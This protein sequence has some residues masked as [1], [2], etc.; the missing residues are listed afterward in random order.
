[1]K[2]K[3]LAVFLTGCSLYVIGQI[4]PENDFFQSPE[5]SA[6]TQEVQTPVSLSTGTLNVEIPLYTLTNGDIK[7]PITMSYDASGVRAESHP[8]WVG[9]NWNLKAGGKIT[10]IVNGLPDEYNYKYTFVPGVADSL[11]CRQGYLYLA[12][13][14]GML[15]EGDATNIQEEAL[16]QAVLDTHLF[17][18]EMLSCKYDYEPDEFIFNFCGQ[19]GVFYFNA[20]GEVVLKGMKGYRINTII[21]RIPSYACYYYYNT[22]EKNIVPAGYSST[23]RDYYVNLSSLY[24]PRIDVS[25]ILGFEITDPQGFKYYFGMYEKAQNGTIDYFRD[26]FSEVEISTPF[27]EELHL[28]QIN[29]WNLTK[30]VSPTGHEE[31]FSYEPGPFLAQLNMCYTSIVKTERWGAAGI[32]QLTPT[33][34]YSGNIIRPSYLAKI[35]GGNQS[36]IFNRVSANDLEYDYT[37][38]A[39]NLYYY[40]S[41]FYNNDN[42]TQA[43]CEELNEKIG[44]GY[45][46]PVS[47]QNYEPYINTG[48]NGQQI[49]R[50]LPTIFR[51][52]YLPKPDDDTTTRYFKGT[53][54]FRNYERIRSQKLQSISITNPGIGFKFDYL[55]E[56]SSRLQLSSISYSQNNQL[57]YAFQYT[58]PCIVPYGTGV[59][60]DCGYINHNDSYGFDF[61]THFGYNYSNPPSINYPPSGSLDNFASYRTPWSSPYV[62]LQA[63]KYPTGGTKEFVFEGN[64][65]DSVVTRSET[66]GALSIVPEANGVGCGLRIKEIRE[67]NSDGTLAKR[68]RYEYA[69]GILNGRCEYYYPTYIAKA[70]STY[71]VYTD[72]TYE[73][74]FTTN[75]LLPISQNPGL[76]NVTYSKVTEIYEDNGKTEYFFSNHDTDPDDNATAM[77]IGR[78]TLFTPLSSRDLQR[79]KLLETKT[80]KEGDPSPVKIETYKYELMDPWAFIPA[81]F[82]NGETFI[83]YADPGFYYKDP[84]TIEDTRELFYIVDGA[85]YKIYT[86]PYNVTKKTESY[87]YPEG[88]TV[89]KTTFFIYDGMN[90]ISTQTESNGIDVTETAY[91]YPYSSYPYHFSEQ[92]YADMTTSNIN[93]PVIDQT[94]TRNGVEI[95]RTRNNYSIFQSLY[96]GP[97]YLPS[98]V[99]TSTTGESGL[100]TKITYDKYDDYGR[101][102][103][104]TSATGKK[105]SYIWGDDG[106][107]IVAKVD[108]CDFDTIVNWPDDFNGFL[109]LYHRPY[110]GDVFTDMY[111]GWS[112]DK[113]IRNIPN[114]LVYSVSYRDDLG[115]ISIIKDPS[116]RCKY[117][118]YDPIGRLTGIQDEDHNDIVRYMYHFI[119]ENIK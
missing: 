98:S 96:N 62:H 5:V 80:Y 8:T 84:T 73:S 26:D 24:T 105:T 56:P 45:P 79:S 95:A 61:V 50:V 41:K 74:L 64:R 15:Y 17:T 67:I 52:S 109:K 92:V 89:S 10:R 118:D 82:I 22:Y 49:Y 70:Y 34:F 3:L 25:Y 44:A 9:L 94:V 21:R 18:T 4:M 113:A 30:I 83:D 19:T 53:D 38:L 40:K 51:V 6:L 112:L 39:K 13:R 54:N 108:N 86:S 58:G 117:Y 1:M 31:T 116:G 28:P 115:C 66:T 93:S 97:L 57:M 75:S 111:N 90:Q 88:R 12:G 110:P 71:I 114:A 11:I 59:G 103:Q 99:Q 72:Y 104:T 48:D 23:L 47:L 119:Y 46:Y 76:G 29:S 27:Y 20:S 91:S 36:A 33:L 37:K 100:K 14:V 7:V 63:I 65:Y 87:N 35:E 107:Y 69:G 32:S 60:D 2:K 55:D 43:V 78:S 81:A 106:R 102:L 85:S 77:V 101:L 42:F 16:K 68:T